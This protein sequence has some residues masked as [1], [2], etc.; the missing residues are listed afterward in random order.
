MT[1]MKDV[2]A[3]LLAA[4]RS[5][6]M[7]SFKPLLPFGR[8]TVIESCVGNLSNGGIKETVVV[9]GHRAREVR[10]QLSNREVKFAV[11]PDPDSQMSASIKSGIQS[12]DQAAAAVVIALADQPAIP[13]EVI[14]QMVFLWREAN[15][16]II[17]PAYKSRRGHPV[18][19]DLLYRH[20]LS[21]LDSDRGLRGFLEKHENQVRVVAVDS[22][23]VA[24]DM[25][26]WE[27]YIRLH[28]E[29]FGVAPR[30]A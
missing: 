13:A 26:T 8:S 1:A 14:R 22:P 3:I 24:R 18:L 11:N 19:I 20:E 2:A 15:A 6:R 10:M 5:R 9:L 25:D 17:Q 28:E 16:P 29:V 30:Q 23:F 21:N 7:G 4:G 12:L 27:D